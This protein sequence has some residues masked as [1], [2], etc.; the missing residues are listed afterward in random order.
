MNDRRP[1]A[2]DR[3]GEQNSAYG[4][5][6]SGRRPSGRRFFFDRIQLVYHSSD[7]LHLFDS[8]ARAAKPK[9]VDARENARTFKPSKSETRVSFAE[10]GPPR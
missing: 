5:S 4:L 9:V 8:G 10:T 6:V 7:E 2:G 3:R 1:A